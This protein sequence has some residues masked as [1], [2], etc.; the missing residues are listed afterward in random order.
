MT[1][2]NYFE[3]HYVGC[4]IN[5]GLGLPKWEKLFESFSIPVFTVGPN[6]L[7]DKEIIKHL[8]NPGPA[9]FLVKIDPDQTY[10]PKITSRINPNGDI[11]SNPIHKMSPDLSP[12]LSELVFKYLL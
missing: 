5:T 8:T 2:K 3:G 7:K 1:Q 10:Y 4:D 11:E 6:D 12:E 9:A